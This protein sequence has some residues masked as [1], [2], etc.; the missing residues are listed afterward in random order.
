MA[1]HWRDVQTFRCVLAGVI[2]VVDVSRECAG[3]NWRIVRTFGNSRKM[4]NGSVIKS[5]MFFDRF[6]LTC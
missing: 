6:V 4:E 2:D 3:G 1:P 5:K